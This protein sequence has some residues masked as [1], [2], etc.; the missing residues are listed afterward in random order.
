MAY[1]R[2]ADAPPQMALD[3]KWARRRGASD[4]SVLGSADLDVRPELRIGGLGDT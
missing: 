3:R 1:L 4:S 2:P